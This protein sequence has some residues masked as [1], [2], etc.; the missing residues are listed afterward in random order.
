MKKNKFVARVRQRLRTKNDKELRRDSANGRF[1]SCKSE[2]A[3]LSFGLDTELRS[4]S[5]APIKLVLSTAPL[6]VMPNSKPSS[7]VARRPT[8]FCYSL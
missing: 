4:L 3:N 6:A 2:R 1:E 5:S 7:S 8:S